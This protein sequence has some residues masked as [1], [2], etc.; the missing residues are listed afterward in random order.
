MKQHGSWQIV[1]SHEI[2]QDPW[3]HVRKGDVVRPDGDPGSYSVVRLKP[4][5]CV[6]AI[7][8]QRNVYLT[9]EF[10]YGVGRVTVEAVSGGIDP[11]E[12]A[13]DTA[14]RELEEELGIRGED[15]TDLG[16]V[17]PFTGSVVSPTRLY[18]V[19]KLTFVARAPEGSEV[20]RCVRMP[21]EQA[22]SD[23]CTSRITHGPSA[24][25]ILK[26]ALRFARRT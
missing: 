8:E 16:S 6:L 21:L 4:G 15:W 26:T 23:V 24:L 18:L 19:E 12:N 7:D 11:G 20:I 17:D 3:I 14:Q 2:Y 25:L 13:F 1:A 9:E 10:H 22:V 5:V